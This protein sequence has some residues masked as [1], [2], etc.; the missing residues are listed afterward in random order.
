MIHHPA[1][2]LCIPVLL[3][4]IDGLDLTFSRLWRSILGVRLAMG[5]IEAPFSLMLFLVHGT[6]PCPAT[7]LLSTLVTCIILLVLY[8]GLHCLLN[9]GVHQLLDSTL[10]VDVLDDQLV[11]PFGRLTSKTRRIGG[12]VARKNEAQTA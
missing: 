10:M 4:S 11:D 1:I 9:K 6:I 12:G 5:L 2:A 7:F 3:L 8:V